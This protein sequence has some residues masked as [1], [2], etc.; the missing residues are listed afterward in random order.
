MPAIL[1]PFHHFGQSNDTSRSGSL[2]LRAGADNPS[3]SVLELW[4][5][6]LE[7]LIGF[8]AGRRFRKFGFDLVVEFD[9]FLGVA[10]ALEVG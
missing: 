8:V 9:R 2:G 10:G 5:E 4:G 1:V 7:P 3:V 6:G